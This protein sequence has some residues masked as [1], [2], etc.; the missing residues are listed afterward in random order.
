MSLSFVKFPSCGLEASELMPP[1]VLFQNPDKNAI[2]GAAG[3][4]MSP[5]DVQFMS[6][7]Y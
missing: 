7:V 2:Y 4:Y 6:K 5:N 3:L 1:G